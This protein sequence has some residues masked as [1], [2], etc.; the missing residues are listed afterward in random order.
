MLNETV[1]QCPGDMWEGHVGN[2]AFWHV[3]YHTLFFTDLYLSRDEQS[4]EPPSFCREDYHFFGQR[5]S[6]PY[7]TVVAEIPYDKDTILEYVRI[8]R[9]KA[10]EA[11]ASETPESLEG[12]VGFWWYKVPRA[13]FYLMNIRHVQHHA[14]H[15]GL[16]LRKAAAIGID[17]VTTV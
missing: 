12:P 1:V 6:P 3:A 5:P 7:E 8:C 11:I 15:M 13:E 4:F 2:Y 10:S 16:Y 14:S 17:F 9:R